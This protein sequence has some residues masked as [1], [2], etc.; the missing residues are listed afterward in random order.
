[1][2]CY[3]SELY[4][5]HALDRLCEEKQEAPSSQYGLLCQDFIEARVS[6]KREQVMMIL[7]CLYYH[8]TGEGNIFQSSKKIFFLPTEHSEAVGLIALGSCG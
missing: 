5:G 3:I 6:T 1:M 4:L 8:N 2:K 7:W